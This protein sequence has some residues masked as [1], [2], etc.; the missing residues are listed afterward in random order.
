MVN[1][2]TPVSYDPGYSFTSPLPGPA[3]NSNNV[4]GTVDPLIGTIS[5]TSF[6]TGAFVTSVKVS[7]FKCGQL[8]AEIWRD[9]QVVLLAGGSNL[10]PVVNPPLNGGTTFSDIVFAGEVVSFALNAQDIQFLPDGSPQ[11][12][13][14]QATGAQ[15][16]SYVPANPPS[17]PI[18]TFSETAGCITASQIPPAP[19]ATLTPAPDPSAPVTGV[20]GVQT[21]FYWQTKCGHLAANTGCGVTSNIYNFVIKVLDNY[22]PAP[23]MN[24][25]VITITILPKPHI[26]SPDIQCLSVLPNG[27]VSLE[28]SLAQDSM[29]SFNSYRVYYSATHAGPYTEIDSIFD[30]NTL[31]YTHVGANAS[32]SAKYYYIKTVSGCPGHAA[33]T[34]PDTFA[35]INVNVVADNLNMISNVSWNATANPLLETSTG[36]YQI[37]RKK[38][39]T[40]WEFIDSTQNTF[41]SEPMKQLR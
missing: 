24:Y 13:E 18:A 39:T 17:V 16:G 11:T 3:Q 22:C 37:Y 26:P 2:T 10:P 8:V 19:C 33:A 12:M 38:V 36:W 30:Y 1:L 4:A 29:I 34:E 28:W 25:S 15:F 23:A 21:Q 5:F 9:I 40:G 41:F 6:T 7:A 20:F 27:D 14:I 31:N 32:D 35:T